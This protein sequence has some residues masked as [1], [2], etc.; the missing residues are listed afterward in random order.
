[1]ALNSTIYKIKL[2]ISDMDRQYY[3][4][5]AL[6]IARHPSETDE[7]MMVRVLAFAMHASDTL[8]LA[9]GLNAVDEPD[10]WERDLT[11]SILKW[12]EVGLPEEKLIRRACGRSNEVWLYTYLDTKTA[13]WWQQNKSG[14]LKLN[15]LR[16]LTVSDEHCAALKSM[17]TRN[18]QLLVTIQD[19]LI[20][21]NDGQTDAHIQIRNL[22]DLV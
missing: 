12:V 4:A 3:G 15:K 19:G 20:W 11:G 21:L 14:L 10:L 1:M 13:I 9:G 22:R 18:L 16:V 7:R 5:H 6:T 17:A 8:A 2:Q